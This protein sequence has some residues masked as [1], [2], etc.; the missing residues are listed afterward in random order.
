[1]KIV[2]FRGR[3]VSDAMDRVKMALGDDA[4]ILDTITRRHEDGTCTVELIVALEGDNDVSPRK[5]WPSRPGR[6]SIVPEKARRRGPPSVLGFVGLNGC[7]KTV[8][9]LKFAIGLVK[10]GKDVVIVNADQKKLGAMEALERACAILGYAF[11]DVKSPMELL[12]LVSGIEKSVCVLIDFP[13]VNLFTDQG[14][15]YLK[16]FFL[17]LP[18][19][20][21]VTVVQ[22]NMH[23]VELKEVHARTEAF[24]PWATVVTKAD[25]LMDPARLHQILADCRQS[26]VYVSRGENISC[27]LE[28]YYVPQRQNTDRSVRP[29]RLGSKKELTRGLYA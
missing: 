9:L 5:T 18:V 19:L 29:G 3:D 1:M 13:G 16:A 17:A 22:A 27:G 21:A 14:L 20:R 2:R 10:R 8:S 15:E 6:A 28:E 26:I 12:K 25:E 7:G 23:P 4:V 11:Y 24:S